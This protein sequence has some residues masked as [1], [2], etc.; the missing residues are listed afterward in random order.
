MHLLWRVNLA[1]GQAEAIGATGFLDME[2][3]AFDSAGVLFGADDESKTLL[4]LNLNSGNGI[5]IGNTKTNMNVPIG[6]AM[7]FGLTLT[8]DDQLLVV[9]DY[10][11][12][13]FTADATSGQLVRIGTEGSLGAPITGIA[14]WGSQVLGIGQGIN[15]DGNLD[16]PNLYRINIDTAEAEL[17]GPLGSQVSPYANAGLAFDADG[18][19]WAVTDRRDNGEPDL[20]SEILRIDIQTGSAQ[21]IADADVVG[22]ESLAIAAPGGCQLQ[23][24]PA[25]AMTIPT[26]NRFGLG[27]LSMF[28]LL[29]SG[30]TLHTRQR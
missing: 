13:L 8:C 7:D 10:R 25:A 28:L 21:K 26:N 29:L 22:F 12:S 18:R 19:L 5:P 17:I 20:A 1:T 11:Q 14:A 3:L 27:L 2:G 6:Q 16:A 4:T 15:A 24:G 30:W 9:S 23:G